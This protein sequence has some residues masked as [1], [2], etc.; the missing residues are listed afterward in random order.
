MEVP[1]LGF[2]ERAAAT[3]WALHWTQI[4]IFSCY[5][6][7]SEKGDSTPWKY[8][9]AEVEIDLYE[10]LE[11][12]RNASKEE[13][14]KAYRKAALGSHPDKVPEEER[15]AA[16]VKFKMV[17]QA[18]DILYDEEKRHLYDTHG[19]GAFN[20]S[21]DPGMGAGPDLD[22]IL[23]QMFGG[24]GG[25]GGMPGGAR[26][27]K[28][29]RSPNEEQKYEV[30]L[31]D[32]YKGR[33]VK[34][35]STKNVI[36][37]LCKGKGG[38]E[39]AQAKKCSTCDGQGFKEVLTRMGPYLTQQTVACSVCKGDGS[40]FSPKDKCKKCKGEK[41][42]EEKKMLE[43]YIPRGA[44]EGDKIVL[45]GEADQVPGQE[46]GDIVFHIAEIEHPTFRR[47]GADLTATLDITLAEAL[48]GFSR[49]VV[50]H[51]DGRGIEITHPKKP[52]QVLHPDQVLKIPGEGMPHKRSDARG[53]L[54]LVVNVKF[55][56]EKWTP[57]PAELEKLREILPKPEPPIQ[58]DVVD[59]VEYD[60][61]GDLEDFGAN[62]PRG[63]SG[64]EDED[65]DEPAQ[66]A[67]Q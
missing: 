8:P 13:I 45:E 16:E 41:V 26:P 9:M 58:T 63:G 14:R 31:E 27:K 51:L 23:A 44:K 35:A 60:P 10:V 4:H 59:E 64:W 30:S 37:S 43:I 47:A 57:S 50:K 3:E 18:Y 7:R 24:M 34:F 12:E 15:E 29:R 66:C 22:D 56:D 53:D 65:D 19:M 33:T 11:I 49:V 21:G 5:S 39:K 67:A 61:Q 2:A 46:P 62:D 20:G 38:K 55:P 25:M 1:A 40:F 36:C 42:T 52:G 17:Q 6:L 54:Y 32:L 48:A 28:P